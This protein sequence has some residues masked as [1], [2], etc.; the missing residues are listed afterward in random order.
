MHNRIVSTI[1]ARICVFVSMMLVAGAAFAADPPIT[2]IPEP[3]T[4]S[5]LAAAGAGLALIVRNRRK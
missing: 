1:V 2:T 5:L 4:L 3:G